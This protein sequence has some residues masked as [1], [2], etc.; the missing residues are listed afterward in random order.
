MKYVNL[1]PHEISVDVD[2]VR[3][4][5][6]STGDCRVAVTTVDEGKTLELLNEAG[7][8]FKVPL[9]RNNY[10]DIEGLPKQEPDTVYIVSLIVLNALKT[11]GRLGYRPD[12]VAPDS[13]PSAIRENGKIVAVRQFVRN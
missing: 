13:G 9:V 3:I 6:P 12:V 7:M 4:S 11:K 10:G 5:I 1:T 2:A 8:K